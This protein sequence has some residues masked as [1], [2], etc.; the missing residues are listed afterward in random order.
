M[1]DQVLT[2]RTLL[3]VDDEA[4]LRDI[5]ASELEFMGAKVFQAENVASAK[6]ILDDQSIDLIVSD[7]RMPGGT[8]IELLEYVKNKN[9]S[10]PPVI[11][12]TGFADITMEDAFDKGAEA[13]VNKPFKL[14]DLINL[15]VKYTEP[16][17]AR[18]KEKFTSTRKL[19]LSFK[20]EIDKKMTTHELSFG[21]GGVAIVIDTFSSKV[22]IG[23]LLNFQFTFSNQVLEG[24]GICR[25]FKVAEQDSSKAFLGLEF[26]QLS[27]TTLQYLSHFVDEHHPKS[28]IPSIVE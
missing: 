7:I 18:F 25:W 5:V 24:V 20:E 17:D 3:V 15:A 26:L 11:L 12:I 28:F 13:L 4:D 22:E 1:E 10:S 23:E 21:R 8:G 14:D 16:F 9:V 19:D 6:K 2:G 27:E